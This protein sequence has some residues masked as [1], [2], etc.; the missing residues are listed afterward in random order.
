MYNAIGNPSS[1]QITVTAAAIPT[2]SPV[3]RQYAGSVTTSTMFCVVKVW[4]TALVNSS[5]PKKAVAS[6]ENSA[7]R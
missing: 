1:V 7:S 3:A 5:T 2:V 4:T 6:N